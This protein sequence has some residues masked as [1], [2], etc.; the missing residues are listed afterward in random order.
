[1]EQREHRPVLRDLVDDRVEQLGVE[2]RERVVVLGAALFGPVVHGGDRSGVATGIDGDRMPAASSRSSPSAVMRRRAEAMIGRDHDTARAVART[3]AVGAEPA[4][5]PPAVP[6]AAGSVPAAVPPA[7]AA[8]PAAAV[9]PQQRAPWQYP[10]PYADGY[11]APRPPSHRENIPERRSYPQQDEHE[12]GYQAEH[13]PRAR[14]RP[15]PAPVRRRKVW[16]WV[17]LGALLVPVLEIR[18]VLGDVR[19]RGRGR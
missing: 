8:R 19:R 12:Y 2:L 13:A 16:P 14:R 6:A 3:A 15:A 11:A 1:M 7:A 18:R 10:D 17:L 4:A 5:A 9:L